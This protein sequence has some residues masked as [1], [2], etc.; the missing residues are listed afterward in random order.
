MTREETVRVG[1]KGGGAAA[2]AAGARFALK[3][4]AGEKADKWDD[5]TPITR[6]EFDAVL[7]PLGIFE[8]VPEPPA[9]RAARIEKE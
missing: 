8:V 4:A 6:A 7:A 2:F 5:G 3:I 9:P 1:V